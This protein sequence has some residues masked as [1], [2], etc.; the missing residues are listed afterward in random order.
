MPEPPTVMFIATAV[1]M[2]CYD[3]SGADAAS[4]LVDWSLQSDIPVVEVATCVVGQPSRGRLRGP[5]P[6]RAGDGMQ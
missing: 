2:E 3:Q 1:L 6:A 5:P 4:I